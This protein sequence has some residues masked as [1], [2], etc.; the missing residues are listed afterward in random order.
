MDLGVIPNLPSLTDVEEMLIA[1]V[2]CFMQ[3]C[4]HRGQQYKYRGHICHFAINVARVFSRLP[5]LPSKL[6][7]IILKP[8]HSD[9]DD[10]ASV[11]RQFKKSWKAH[12]SGYSDIVINDEAIQELPINGY[13]DDQFTVLQHGGID[14]GPGDYPNTQEPV[15]P[16]YTPDHSPPPSIPAATAHIPDGSPPN[17]RPNTSADSYYDG[18]SI[19]DE[20]DNDDNGA[21]TTVVPNIV[22]DVGEFETLH[23]QIQSRPSYFT[24]GLVRRT[25]ISKYSNWEKILSLAFPTLYPNGIGD[26]MQPRMREVA[27]ADYVQHMISYKDGRFAH[28]SRFR[29]AA[30]NTLLRR[31]TT[32]KAGFFVRKTL[33]GAS[34]TAEDI[35]A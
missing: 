2:H 23:R 28:H 14:I 8:P 27:Y 10:H 21:D 1:Q 35:Q 3:I 34:M 25:P 9:E 17:T 30:F 19:F 20:D 5:V 16:S 18:S 29:F 24:M 11:E 7:I 22:P 6:N 33:D 12:H 15:S 4:Q 31:Q 32:A 13:V 26:Y